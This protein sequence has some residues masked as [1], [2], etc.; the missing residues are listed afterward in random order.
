MPP[1]WKK[2]SYFA[3]VARQW[4][5]SSLLPFFSSQSIIFSVTAVFFSPAGRELSQA[6]AD[7]GSSSSQVM[8]AA[9]VVWDEKMMLDDE[10]TRTTLVREEKKEGKTVYRFEISR[11]EDYN[12]YLDDLLRREAKAAG[13]DAG[14]LG[15]VVRQNLKHLDI[16]Q[17]HQQFVE[18]VVPMNPKEEAS[19]KGFSMLPEDMG[20]TSYRVKIA[21]AGVVPI[22]AKEWRYSRLLDLGNP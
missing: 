21:F 20:K 2:R 8:V 5:A 16:P 10:A 3:K 13:V 17:V 14:T 18:I 1:L 11:R 15:G 7:C 19:F 6:L 12:P 9:A 4:F 22:G